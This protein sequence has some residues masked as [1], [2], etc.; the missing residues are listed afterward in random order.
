MLSTARATGRASWWFAHARLSTSPRN[1]PIESAVNTTN[2]P[3]PQLHSYCTTHRDSKIFTPTVAPAV[4]GSDRR[5]RIAAIFTISQTGACPRKKPSN[6]ESFSNSITQ[7]LGNVSATVRGAAGACN[8]QKF[9]VV[10][11]AVANAAIAFCIATAPPAVFQLLLALGAPWGALTMGGFHPGQ[12]P[13]VLR[14]NAVFSALI[15]GGAALVVC[16]RAG[17]TPGRQDAVRRSVWV[18]VACALADGRTRTLRTCAFC[19][20]TSQVR[21]SR[22]FLEQSAWWKYFCICSLRA[23]GS[24]PCGCHVSP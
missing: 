21:S 5:R 12:L 19:Q 14:L 24:V 11:M 23:T 8:T 18:V 15:L 7:R 16:V 17:L 10:T 9:R 20:I 2:Q 3:P 1:L 4:S 13:P 6:V 22:I